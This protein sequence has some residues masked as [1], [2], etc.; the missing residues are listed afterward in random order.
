MK[1]ERENEHNLEALRTS[2]ESQHMPK[3]RVE[4]MKKEME[5]AKMK[6][7]R[8]EKATHWRRGVGIAAAVLAAFIILPNTSASVAHAMS[9][10]PL[11]GRLVDVVTFRSYQ[12]EDDRNSADVE[13][14][15][16]VVETVGQDEIITSETDKEQLK[17]AADSINGE[18]QEITDKL[19]AEFKEGLSREEGY[20][21]MTVNSEVIATTPDYFT[22]KLMCFQSAGSGYE[23]DYYYT[24]DLKTKERLQLKDLFKEGADYITPI[25]D[26]IKKQMKE[27]MAADPNT[28][29][30]LDSDMPEWD[31]RNI[32]DE[33]GFYLDAEGSLVIS[34]NEGDVAPMS[35]GC[36]SFTIEPDAI[37]DIL[38]S[39]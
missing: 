13:V 37:A 26:N 17:Q 18:I 21:S 23:Q 6:N 30:W 12:Y 3:E 36:V 28:I 29:Y 22:L 38:K 35:M 33:T 16:V 24:I 19:I 39:K 8:E 4:Q 14:P 5:R 7:R 27:Q 20:Q 25:S 1:Q 34:F 32:T 31:F 15:G 2:Y 11:L 10:I 9:D